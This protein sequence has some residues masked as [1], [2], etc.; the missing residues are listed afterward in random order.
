M[1]TRSKRMY[2]GA[3]LFTAAFM[4]AYKIPALFSFNA[5]LIASNGTNSSVVSLSANLSVNYTLWI[6]PGVKIVRGLIVHQHGCGEGSCKSG[7]TGAFDLHW[8][9]LARKH[10]CALMSP[11]YEQ[12]EEADC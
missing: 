4:Q 7:L 1:T 6:P 11:S 12:P 10:R 8:Q 2:G 5:L 3:A 9:A